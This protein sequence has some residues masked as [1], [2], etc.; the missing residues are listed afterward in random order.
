MTD[1]PRDLTRNITRHELYY[2]YNVHSKSWELTT[3]AHSPINP[4]NL[5][6]DDILTFYYNGYNRPLVKDYN[7]MTY[8]NKR[9]IGMALF[10]GSIAHTIVIY[11]EVKN[12]Y[13]KTI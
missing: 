5:W 3:E 12:E 11:T 10:L 7:N 8:D 1:I 6:L 2:R 4:Y 13:S 9:I